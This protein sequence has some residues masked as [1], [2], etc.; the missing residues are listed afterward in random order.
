MAGSTL[1]TILVWT[2]IFNGV[3]YLPLFSYTTVAEAIQ[4]VVIGAAFIAF[5][6]IKPAGLIPERAQRFGPKRSTT[7][8]P[9]TSAHDSLGSVGR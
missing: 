8:A 9:S 6:V 4:I 7:A 3:Q 1:G 5:I 2:V